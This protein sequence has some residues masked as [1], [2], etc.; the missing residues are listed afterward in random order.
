MDEVLEFIYGTEGS[1]REILLFLHREIT[2]IDGVSPKIRYKIPFYYRK[3]WLCY[4]N[5]LKGGNVELA[6]TRGNELS[7]STGMLSANGRKQVLGTVFESVADIPL[8]AVRETLHEALLL[9]AH[10][11]YS[12][13]RQK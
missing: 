7:N 13:K 5:P 9:D 2:S 6:F 10:V 4:L 1:Q 3:S 12:V 8:A 11:P